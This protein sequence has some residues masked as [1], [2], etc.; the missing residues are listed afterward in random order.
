MTWWITFDIRGGQ[1]EADAI[2]DLDSSRLVLSK[3]KTP[4]SPMGRGFEEGFK[5]LAA[6]EGLQ[7][8]RCSGQR[9]EQEQR[10]TA[11]RWSCIWGL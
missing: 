3:D 1:N 5:V 9:E 11:G 8:R 4:W 7:L 2:L 10:R 6:C